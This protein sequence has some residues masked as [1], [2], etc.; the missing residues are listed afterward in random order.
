MGKVASALAQLAL[1]MRPPRRSLH[2]HRGL[3]SFDGRLLQHG[4]RPRDGILR[5]AALSMEDTD[6][7][8]PTIP[9]GRALE[10]GATSAAERQSEG[11]R[12]SRRVH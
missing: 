5:R 3:L 8:R 4:R 2:D 11:P 6:P 10:G 12:Q 1:T 7:A 9:H